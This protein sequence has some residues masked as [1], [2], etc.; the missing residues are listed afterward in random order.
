MRYLFGENTGGLEKDFT[1]LQVCGSSYA[2]L[3]LAN[4]QGGAAT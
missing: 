3:A 1:N 2:L 4:T